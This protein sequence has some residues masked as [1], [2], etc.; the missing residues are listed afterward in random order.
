MFGSVVLPPCFVYNSMAIKNKDGTLYRLR[1]PNPLMGG[2][3]LWQDFKVHNMEFGNETQEDTT[4][5]QAIA[6]D[7]AVKESFVGELQDKPAPEIKV[8][9]R[10]TVSPTPKIEPVRIEARPAPVVVPDVTE[11]QEA[12]EDDGLDKVFVHCLPASIRERKDGIYGD[13]YR[14]IQYGNPYS[15]EG[16]IVDQNDL[17][18][19][20]WTTAEQTHQGSILFPKNGTRRW[21]RVQDRENKTGGWLITAHPSDYQPAFG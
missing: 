9:E 13:S 16:V 11:T 10:P 8:D 18:L 21:W 4:E 19:R 15:F 6:S 7:F 17:T 3:E 5:V 2:Q 14:T 20:L 1:G 12:E